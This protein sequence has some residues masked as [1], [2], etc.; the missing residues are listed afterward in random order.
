MYRETALVV[1]PLAAAL[2]ESRTTC[3]T[4]ARLASCSVAGV[5]W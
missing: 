2:L 3:S 4:P 5:F 1:S